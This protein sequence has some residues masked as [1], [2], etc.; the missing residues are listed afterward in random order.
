MVAYSNMLAKIT[1][2]ACLYNSSDNNDVVFRQF[3]RSQKILLS[4]GEVVA[5]AAHKI[6]E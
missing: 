1:I 2:Y 4:D 6:I 5:T 3:R